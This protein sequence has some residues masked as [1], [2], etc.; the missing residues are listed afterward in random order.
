MTRAVRA[1]GIVVASA[2]VVSPATAK[3]NN[4]NIDLAYT[5]TEE[6]AATE[7]SISRQLSDVAL[8][9]EVSDERSVDSVEELGIRTDGDDREHQLV[10]TS[11]VIEF[12]AGALVEQAE[13]WDLQLTEGEAALALA[14]TVERLEILETNQAVGATYEAWVEL[15]VTLRDS[16]GN[17][18]WTGGVAGD[19]TRYGRKFSNDNINEVLSDALAEAFGAIVDDNDFDDAAT[20][21]A[22]G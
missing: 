21:A 17:D 7:V 5:P 16:A 18:L 12:V 20:E 14:I 9:L 4:L 15:D 10:A 8:A 11:D 13:D 2:L 22:A 1:A 19:A 6:V 3:K